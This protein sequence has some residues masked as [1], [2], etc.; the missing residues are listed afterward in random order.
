MKHLLTGVMLAL[1][2]AA[3]ASAQQLKPRD[4]GSPIKPH[5]QYVMLFDELAKTVADNF[6]DPYFGGVD[7]RGVTARYR[8]RLRGVRTDEAFHD[9]ALAML[10]ELK[11]SHVELHRPAD[12][13][14][15]TTGIGVRLRLIGD[16]QVVAEVDPLSD[17][18]RQGLR[19]GHVLLSPPAQLYGGLGSTAQPRVRTCTGQER[20]VAVRRESVF[21]PPQR[22]SLRWY[23]VAAAPGKRIGY[24]RVDRFDDD[25]A[26]LADRAMADLKDTDALII[27]IRQNGGGNAAALRLASYFT[28]EAAPSVI[29]L[30]RP[31]LERLGRPLTA[32]DA[33]AAPRA[34]GVYTAE[35][36]F[37]ALG[38]HGGAVALWTEDMG[39]RRYAAPVIVLVGENTGSAAEGFAWHMRLKT[40]ATLMGRK[41]AGSLLGAETFELEGGWSV[42]LP[43]HGIWGP[44]GVDYGDRAVQPH[45]V[46]PHSRNDLCA[47]RDP[48]IEAAIDRVL[49]KR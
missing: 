15:R 27:D 20:I 38:A 49:G 23:S 17:A 18:R 37:E 25:S 31:W 5:H 39:E 21:W 26:P 2:L 1:A 33:L 42:T 14:D 16:E 34:D 40:G 29:L 10:R 9:L 46:V 24:L 43:V 8:E 3:P 12:G 45:V 28:A 11:S 44:D 7:W 13:D 48:E 41:T 36:V 6:Y 47:G 32:Q 4:R 22:P 35:K 19:P 30:T